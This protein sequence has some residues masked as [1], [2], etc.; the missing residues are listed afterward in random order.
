VR[1]ILHCVIPNHRIISQDKIKQT[2]FLETIKKSCYVIEERSKDSFVRKIGIP[3]ISE[4]LYGTVTDE[5]IKCLFETFITAI[6]KNEFKHIKDI[7]IVCENE[8]VEK[9][10]EKVFISLTYPWYEKILTKLFGK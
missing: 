6:N 1:F 7:V 4:T 9:Q 3:N 5:D 2:L 10:Y 8:V